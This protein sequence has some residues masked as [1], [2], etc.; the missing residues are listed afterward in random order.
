MMKHTLFMAATLFFSAAFSTDCKSQSSTKSRTLE[1]VFTD[2]T[3]QFTGIAK[4]NGGSL[5]L[6]YPRW[7]PVYKYA[8]VKTAGNTGKVPYPTA[9]MNSWQPGQRGENKWV[10]VQ[11]MYIDD[12]GDYWVIDPAAP[13]LKTVQGNGA[14]LVKLDKTRRCRI[15]DV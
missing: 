15:K 4:A 10:C 7:S 13:M 5:F 9:S 14:K 8:V 11:S 6:I 3:Y 12:A 1:S 2:D